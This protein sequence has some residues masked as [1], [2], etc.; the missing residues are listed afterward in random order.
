MDARHAA[1]RAVAD[2]PAAPPPAASGLRRRA[3]RT[4]YLFRYTNKKPAPRLP[5]CRNDASG[6]ARS[7]PKR[8]RPASR[9]GGRDAKGIPTVSFPVAVV[10]ARCL[11]VRPP[12]AGRRSAVCAR[13]TTARSGGSS[14]PDPSRTPS[15]STASSPGDARTPRTPGPRTNARRHAARGPD[16]KRTRRADRPRSCGQGQAAAALMSAWK[17]PC[18]SGFPGTHDASGYGTGSSFSRRRARA[19]R[20]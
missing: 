7:V 1:Q 8:V 9:G 2:R 4:A 12:A 13:A 20:A 11:T 17:L 15:G 14:L 19:A 6:D 16:S 18:Y 5:P 10:F 3:R